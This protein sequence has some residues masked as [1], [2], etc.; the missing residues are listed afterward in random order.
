MGVAFEGAA[1]GPSASDRGP[2]GQAQPGH[3]AVVAE[4][5]QPGGRVVA[6]PAGQQLGLPGHGG[7]LEALELLDDGRQAGVAGQLGSGGQVL[8]SQAGSA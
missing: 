3:L 6:E 5:V 2:G 1:A 4:G 8:P 7:R